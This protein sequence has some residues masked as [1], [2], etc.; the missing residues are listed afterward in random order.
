VTYGRRST[1][2]A[3]LMQRR[4]GGREEKKMRKYLGFGMKST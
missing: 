4:G 3:R 2:I 1:E